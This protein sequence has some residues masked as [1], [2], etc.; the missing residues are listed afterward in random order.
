MTRHAPSRRE[1][2]LASGTLFAWAHLPRLARAEGRDPRLLVIVLRG[3]L[4]GLAAVAPVG[5]P[6]WSALRGDQALTLD[7]KTPALPL[8]SF[9]ALHPAMI[10][11]H[12]L[13]HAG[14]RHDRA[15]GGDALSR[16]LPFR[17]PGR[18]GERPRSTGGDRYRMAQPRA[19]HPGARRPRRRPAR[20]LC[21]RTDCAAGGT[22]AGAGAVMD[23]ATPAA[24]GRR[25]GDAADGALSPHRSCARP[26]AR[27]ARGAGGDRTRGR[28]GRRAAARPARRAGAGLFRGGG[29]DSGEVPGA[30]GRPA[31]RCARL[32]RLGHA[33]RRRGGERPA[34]E[35]AG[36][37]RR[38]PGCGR[39]RDEGRLARD[40]GGGGD[41]VRPH[42]AH[43]RHRGH[44]P[45]HGDGRAAC[46]RCAQGRP[47]GRRLAG[48]A[49]LR[50]AR[51]RDL[52][53]T[54]DLRAVLK[55]LLQD[56]LRVADSAL[57]T[58]VFPES[59]A[60]QPM[61]GLLRRG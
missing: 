53:P 27:G 29:G 52:K 34:R 28:D 11:L 58:T 60:V 22:W 13:Y 42:G 23:A 8:D 39:D 1:L 55:G 40:G 20:C 2:L 56:H 12:R 9:F 17:R 50:P 33:C 43:Q 45:R 7:G 16:A 21:D 41:R 26:R 15:C 36:R 32:R 44:R 57:A 10:N 30:T 37:A 31:G 4:D 6:D 51:G 25:H 24:R 48:A 54:T 5:D 59:G 14:A 35:P 47:C 49:S 18:A 61:A 3:A 38:R 46:G 19:L